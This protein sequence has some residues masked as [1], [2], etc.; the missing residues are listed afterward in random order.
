[1]YINSL[2]D[3][4]VFANSQMVTVAYMGDSACDDHYN[5]DYIND[6]YQQWDGT[7]YYDKNYGYI[8]ES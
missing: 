4:T 6:V 5:E 3:I 8:I 1:M 2:V 7:L